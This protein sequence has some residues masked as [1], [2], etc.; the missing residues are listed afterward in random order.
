M[1]NTSIIFIFT[2]IKVKKTTQMCEI[3]YYYV[4]RKIAKNAF[5]RL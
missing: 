4:I 5:Y 3:A 1:L 2:G